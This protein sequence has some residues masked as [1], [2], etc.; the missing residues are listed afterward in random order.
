MKIST[1]K[2]KVA[3][4]EKGA[5]VPI[6]GQDGEAYTA[7]DG[8]PAT[9]TLLGSESKKLRAVSDKQTRRVLR[10]QRTKMTPE[11]LRANRIELATAAVID[12]HGFE[13]DAGNPIPCTA[14]NVAEVLAA[15]PHVLEQV[16]SGVRRHA[17][18]FS[19]SSPTS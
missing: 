11:E 5:I 9:I 18:F 8:S 16:E 19:A 14:E 12:W 13:D 7:A 17:S 6:E 3:E 4:S 1:L 2:T 15:A 10:D